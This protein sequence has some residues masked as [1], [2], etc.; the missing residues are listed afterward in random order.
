MRRTGKLTIPL[1][2]ERLEDRSLLSTASLSST[3]LNIYGTSLADTITVRQRSGY[4]SIDG[5]TISSGSSSL[6]RVLAT[7]V[8]KI[9]IYGYGGNDTINCASEAVTGQQG[10]AKPIRVEAGD[11]DDKVWG[12]I[13]NDTILGGY[14]NDKLYGRGG[15]D[16]IEGG[17]G[18]DYMHGGIGNDTMYGDEGDDE[19]IGSDGND[20]V[21][22]ND[23]AD[24][25]YG[26]AG[27]DKVYGG[28]GN[29]ILNGWTGNDYLSGWS[30]NDTL[31]GGDGN[32][33]M[34]GGSGNDKLYGFNGIDKLYGESGDDYLKGGAGNDTIS[35]GSGR[36]T[37]YRHL[38]MPSL[39]L[40]DDMDDEN[41]PADEPTQ[42]AGAFLSDSAPPAKD[43]MYHIDQEQSPVCA[44]MAALAGVADW[45]GRFPNLGASNK[46][47]LSFIKYNATS[48]QY[49]IPLYINGKWSTYWVTGD[50]TENSMPAGPLWTTLYLKAYLKACNVSTTYSDGTPIDPDYWYSTTGA[51]WQMAGFAVKSLTGDSS[52]WISNGSMNSQTMKNQITGG[53]LLTASSN[54]SASNV[55]AGV[56]AD[57]AYYVYDVYLSSGV[58]YVKL[59]NPWGHDTSGGAQYG[60]DDGLIR[61][62]WAQFV[63]NFEGYYKN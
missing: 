50:W 29:D 21:S 63:A 47:L 42:V 62:T 25:V 53:W 19:V 11:G 54:E 61:L 6:S 55:S 39:A 7:S 32:D 18:N 44:F 16:R 43:N 45:T 34:Y 14:N 3:V 59:Y 58:W 1:I 33:T 12:S 46:D 57:H 15:A 49:G 36:D 20:L 5:L 2:L 4:I 40:S 23:G 48:D 37:F 51:D 28:D 56:V 9:N 13:G 60:S 24:K 17:S 52:T 26:D 35:G 10:I 30:G 22:G 41:A 8:S 27:D 31:Y 38:T